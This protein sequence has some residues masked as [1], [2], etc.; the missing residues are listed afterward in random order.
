M[1]ASKHFYSPL[2]YD[3][4]HRDGASAFGTYTQNTLA[5]EVK[6]AF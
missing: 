1:E 5:F 4:R 2:T 3:F 6:Y